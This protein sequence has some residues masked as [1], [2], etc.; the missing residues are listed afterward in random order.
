MVVLCLEAGYLQTKTDKG[1]VSKSHL[2][3]PKNPAGLVLRVLER[4]VLE[5][6]KY[7]KYHTESI[8]PGAVEK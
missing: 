1:G 5:K 7:S 2:K 6:E 4:L 3:L 8:V